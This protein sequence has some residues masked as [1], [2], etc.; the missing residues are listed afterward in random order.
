MRN[1]CSSTDPLEC[2]SACAPGSCERTRRVRSTLVLT[3]A[4][5]ILGVLVWQGVSSRGN[6]DPLATGI[7]PAAAI[8]NTGILV[9]REGLEA[10]LVLAALTTTLVR[11]RAGLWKPI[12]IGAGLSLLAS[13][14]TW[15]AVVAILDSINAPALQ[16]QAATGLLAIVVLLVIM[17][18]YFHRIYWAGWICLHERRKRAILE[19]PGDGAAIYWGLVL[20]GLTAVY[21]EGFEVV[22]FLQ[23]LRL[24]AGNDLVLTGT[25]IGLGLT[26]IVAVLTFIAQRKL[27]YRKML[28]ATGVM[29]G[30]VLLVMTG[31]SAQ[32]LQQAGW[33]TTTSIAL[34]LPD[35]LG[36]WLAVFPTVESLS[37]QG[38]AAILVI[39]SYFLARRRGRAGGTGGRAPGQLAGDRPIQITFVAKDA[40]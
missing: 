7:S 34:Q 15:F 24:R 3:A 39:G 14:A 25:A 6:P 33:I 32:E 16:V 20:L 36:T 8:V 38:V 5:L 10:V 21:R 40:L 23:S 35:W 2:P 37:A 13:V 4:L 22:L 1:H 9:F 26:S 28:V 30:G 29:L 11:T 19:S 18:W 31:E 27:P 12:A 17:N